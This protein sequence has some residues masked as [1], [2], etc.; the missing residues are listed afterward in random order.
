MLPFTVYCSEVSLDEVRSAIMAV[1]PAVSPREVSRVLAGM[2]GVPDQGAEVSV[3]AVP[4]SE[5]ALRLSQ[6]GLQHLR[7]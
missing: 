1:D 4:H 7:Q 3:G 5:V 2:F 6:L